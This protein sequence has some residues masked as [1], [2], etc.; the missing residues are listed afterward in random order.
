MTA[1]VGEAARTRFGPTGEEEDIR[2][3]RPR[4]FTFRTGQAAAGPVRNTTQ[5]E[6]NDVAVTLA[7]MRPHDFV[8]V[9]VIAGQG[10]PLEQAAKAVAY[11]VSAEERTT[12]SFARAVRAV[13]AAED[14]FVRPM[15][16]TSAPPE[17]TAGW[18]C[19]SSCSDRAYGDAAGHGTRM[20]RPCSRPSSRSC[21]ASTAAS[22]G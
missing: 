12:Y 11:E 20:P 2:F 9:T 5:V 21:I 1:E 18:A 4:R 14:L 10:T 6:R 19:A 8:D 3:A 17:P 13:N 22:S 15:R 7:E 16:S